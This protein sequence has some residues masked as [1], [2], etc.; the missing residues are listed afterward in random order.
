MNLIQSL[1]QNAIRGAIQSEVDRYTHPRIAEKVGFAVGFTILLLG[2]SR[3]T[4]AARL[5][6]IEDKLSSL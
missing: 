5:K 6:R 3:H 1:T 2:Y 4:R